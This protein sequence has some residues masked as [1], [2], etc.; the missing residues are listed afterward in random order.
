MSL[1][2]VAFPIAP[3]MTSTWREWIAELN[4]PRRQEFA[5]S[6]D[7]AGV[8][9]RTFLQESPQ[10]DLVIVTLEG[11]DPAGSFG[12]MMNTRDSF[13]RWFVAK[14]KEVHGVDLTDADMTVPS[15]MVIDSELVPAHVS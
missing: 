11:D 15:V 2:A 14:V 13:T 8:R 7:H 4:G 6:R 1:M 10:G 3:G 9:E 12:K 5:D